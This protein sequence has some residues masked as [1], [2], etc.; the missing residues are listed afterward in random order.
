MTDDDMEGLTAELPRL[1]GLE[2]GIPCPSNSC[3]TTVASLLPISVHCLDLTTIGAHFNTRTIVGDVQRLL[4]EGV[5][6]EKAK[7]KLRGLTVGCSPLEVSED[8]A[9]TVAM[10]FKVI[11]PFLEDFDSLGF[12]GWD[13]VNLM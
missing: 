10:A 5:G 12:N 1:K 9:E 7:R 3:N 11:F 2:L 8:D 13:E 6:R 4:N